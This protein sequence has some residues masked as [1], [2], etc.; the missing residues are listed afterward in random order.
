MARAS[1]SDPLHAFR[2]HVRSENGFVE[3]TDSNL[4]EAGFQSVSM[5][6]L[7]VEAVE[8]KEGIWTYTRKYAGIPTVSDITLMRGVTKTNTK[9]F[10]W[11]KAAAE[12]G[13]YRSNI[14]VYHWH[15]DGKLPF[16]LA[17][18][19]A[20]R[21]INCFECIP[22]R[23]KAAGDLDATSSEVSLEEMD[24]AMEYFSITNAA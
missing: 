2:F 12:G 24:I 3:F 14:T 4:G 16:Q 8:Y 13:E 5:P 11:T 20:A 22:T 10:D 15:R 19:A 17:D 6:E 23:T 1:A 7:S 18:L 21:Q 9:F